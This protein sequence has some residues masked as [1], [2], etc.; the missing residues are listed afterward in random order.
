MVMYLRDNP[1]KGV[2]NP[3]LSEMWEDDSFYNAVI[4]SRRDTLRP[5][6]VLRI[7][8]L[9]AQG[10]TTAEIVDMVGA[11]NERQVRDVVSG[12]TYSRVTG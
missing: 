6:Q 11:R 9:A 10:L 5:G 1:R 12:K 2:P 3:F 4:F 7:R 8:N